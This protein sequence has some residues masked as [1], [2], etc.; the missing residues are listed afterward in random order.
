MTFLVVLTLPAI[1]KLKIAQN[2]M[3]KK[4]ELEAITVF[5]FMAYHS[6]YNMF[7]NVE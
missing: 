6:E 4:I 7:R 1:T 3:V 2:I 5:T